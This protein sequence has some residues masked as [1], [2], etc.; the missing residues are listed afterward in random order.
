MLLKVKSFHEFNPINENVQSAKSLLLKKA[1]I[2]KKRRLKLPPEEKVQLTPEEEKSALNN[3]KYIE[4]RDYCLNEIKKPGLVYPFTYFT[5][6]EDLSMDGL[7]DLNDKIDEVSPMLQTFPLPMGN[8]DAYVKYKIDKTNEDPRPAYEIL[9]EDIDF[10]LSQKVVKEFVDRFVGPVRREYSKSLKEKNNN[11]ERAQLL[12]RLY[13]AVNDIKKLKPY[14]NEKNG[15]LEIA[16]EQLVGHGSKYKDTE[17]YPE[18]KDT[19]VAF[20]SFVDDCEYKVEGWGTTEDMFITDLETIAPSIKILYYNPKSRIVVTSSRSYKG[21]ISLCKIANATYCIQNQSTFWSKTSGKLQISINMLGLPKSDQKY[22]TS[23]TINPGRIVTESANRSNYSIHYDSSDK[24]YIKVLQDYGIYEE[25]YVKAIENYFSSEL[26]IKDILER[27][28]RGSL[29]RPDKMIYALGGLELRK[30]IAEGLFTEEEMIMYKNLI[31]SILKK[32]H[33]ISYATI[34]E[35]F[36]S[37]EPEAPGGFWT[38]SDVELFESLTDKKYD[39][40]DLRKIYDITLSGI[41]EIP[42]FIENMG[43]RPA[44]VKLMEEILKIHPEIKAYVE[45]N[46][47]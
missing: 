26:A 20:K 13:H 22:L 14:T 27:I 11:T 4:V 41:A 3:P 37:T 28:E 34:I 42:E 31:I 1:L 32:D 43:H 7:K 33:N 25:E 17:N 46:M 21:I 23:M 30:S 40:N 45:N 16:E 19:Y 15:N 36:T 8:I 10:I 24:N 12:D 39:K 38:M 29:G 9:D 47:L 35:C 5:L 18:F 44:M 6:V 2:D